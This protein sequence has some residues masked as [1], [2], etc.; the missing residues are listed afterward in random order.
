MKPTLIETKH[1]GEAMASDSSSTIAYSHAAE[2]AVLEFGR[3]RLLLRQR[4]LMADG[5]PI[6]LGAR[7]FE[8]LL[9]LIEAEGLVL[10]KD[11]LMVRVWPGIVVAPENL[12]VQIA[13]LRKALGESRDF[14]RTEF[15]RGYRFTAAVRRSSIAEPATL[16]GTGGT[17]ALVGPDAALPLQVAAIVAQLA[18]L[19]DKLA[20]A[21][22]RL[23]DGAQR[24]AAPF[25]RHAHWVSFSGR[26]KERSSRK[27]VEAGKV[28]LMARNG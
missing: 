22:Q 9:A 12:K 11:A 6:E 23:D 18:C 16:P 28:T 14:I 2:D 7:A 27:G 1:Q 13:A 10:T 8:L 3:F 26:T 19:E 25:H 15:G 4:R 20:Q 24:K 17:G 5:A 21:L